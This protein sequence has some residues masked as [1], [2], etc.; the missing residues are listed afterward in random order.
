MI[1]TL[2]HAGST[3]I[4]MRFANKYKHMDPGQGAK[5]QSIPYRA[6]FVGVNLVAEALMAMSS[7]GHGHGVKLDATIDES[8]ISI[9]ADLI[10]K[11]QPKDQKHL[12]QYMAGFLSQPEVLNREQSEIAV[13]LDRHL[14]LLD[15]HPWVKEAEPPSEHVLMNDQH[16][17]SA[18]HHSWAEK[19]NA[20]AEVTSQDIQ[21][22]VSH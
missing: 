20:A 16:T 6:A 7:K 5:M 11:Q 22:S 15:S 14:K 13:E 19:V 9:V 21:P 1:S 8:M 10:H 17:K 4:D 12:I 18:D 3:V 2:C